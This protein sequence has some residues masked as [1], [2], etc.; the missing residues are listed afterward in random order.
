MT[1]REMLG[2]L[3]SAAP[4]LATA[5]SL[6]GADGTKRKRLGVCTYS[7]NLH[8]KAAREGNP[9]A[10]F[11]DPIEFL[12]YCHQL[13]AGG[14][15]VAIGR[16]DAGYTTSLRTR[17]EAL[18]MYLEGESSLPKQEPDVARFD[19][20][21]HAAKEA[22]AEVVRTALLG[23]RR[24]ETFD[25]AEAFRQFAEQSWKS[26]TLAEPVARRHGIKLAVENHKDWR[27]PELVDI[28]KRINSDYVGSC[29]DTGNNIALLEDPMESVEALAPFAFSTHLKDMAVQEYEDGFLLS[30][31]PLGDGFL[32]LE[33]IIALLR[34]ANPKIQFNL[35]MIT[36]D[37]LKIPCLSPKY[38]ATMK[39]VPA[40]D[41]ATTLAMVRRN[42]AKQPLPHTSG[43]D[44]EQQLALEDKNVRASFAHAGQHL[45]L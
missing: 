6:L 43:L 42:A 16:R 37:P 21:I 38:W 7:Y 8:W 31:V 10:R 1:R 25:S 2:L 35:E 23:G 4:M 3:A 33:K 28:L 15:Q 29:V 40:R 14:V 27:A 11:H 34:N 24:Y 12:E 44:T 41:L 9:K 18:G 20:E 32:D 45:G 17:A 36:R 19:A 22:G 26:L 13:G 5:T 30:E 39:T